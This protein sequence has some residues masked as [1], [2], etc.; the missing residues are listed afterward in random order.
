[1]KSNTQPF[2]LLVSHHL[3][4][5]TAFF[6]VLCHIKTTASCDFGLWTVTRFGHVVSIFIMFNG[7]CSCIVLRDQCTCPNNQSNVVFKT[8]ICLLIVHTFWSYD[9]D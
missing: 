4:T 1:M 2:A 8:P 7:H 5:F 3:M 6:G 9:H